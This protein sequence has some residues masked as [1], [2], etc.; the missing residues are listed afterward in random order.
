MI[1]KKITYRHDK[2]NRR[3][4]FFYEAEYF[5]QNTGHHICGGNLFDVYLVN[6]HFVVIKNSI[7]PVFC[8]DTFDELVFYV[9]NTTKCFPELKKANYKAKQNEQ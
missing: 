5:D 9:K 6:N 8:C 3:Y 1:Y 2:K 4:R 7:M